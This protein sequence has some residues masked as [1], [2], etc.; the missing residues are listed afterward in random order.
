[1]TSIRTI[2]IV[3]GCALSLT[4]CDF[5]IARDRDE[6]A[7][8][9]TQEPEIAPVEEATLV[10]DQPDGPVMVASTATIDWDAARADLAAT[11]SE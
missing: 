11:P 6:P 1:M 4:A 10:P 3:G 7:P 2:L 8:I 5:L 9:E